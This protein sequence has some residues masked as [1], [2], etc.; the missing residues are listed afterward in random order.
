[1]LASL[2]DGTACTVENVTL[3]MQLLE[4][5]N[6]SPYACKVIAVLE[7]DPDDPQI[8][9]KVM[10]ADPMGAEGVSPSL[11]YMDR[12]MEDITRSKN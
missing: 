2:P 11:M 12:F 8:A 1:M 10:V 7:T 4:K 9:K 6:E 5:L 3:S